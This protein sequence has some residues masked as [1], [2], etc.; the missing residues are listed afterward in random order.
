MRLTRC[1]IQ[2]VLLGVLGLSASWALAGAGT[3]QWKDTGPVTKRKQNEVNSGSW[4]PQAQPAPKEDAENPYNEGE[5]SET[6]DDGDT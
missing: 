5:D 6:Y 2:L 4:Q 3:P 1:A